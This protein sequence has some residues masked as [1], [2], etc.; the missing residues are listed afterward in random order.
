MDRANL[1]ILHNSLTH[2]FFMLLST[3][4]P[5]VL[6][7]SNTVNSNVS[8]WPQIR[9]EWVGPTYLLDVTVT[10]C[11]NQV[12]SWP[13]STLSDRTNRT[14]TVDHT[15]FRPTQSHQHVIAESCAPY[16]L[17]NNSEM[18][19]SQGA[20]YLRLVFS[21]ISSSPF[22]ITLLINQPRD[23]TCTIPSPSSR[24]LPI[25]PPTPCQILLFLDIH[26]CPSKTPPA[27]H[28]SCPNNMKHLEDMRGET[29]PVTST[30]TRNE[31]P[32]CKMH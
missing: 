16:C 18:L 4:T 14:T 23:V 3:H 31:V 21:A 27:L 20:S 2:L 26:T 32:D 30:C 22:F 29:I 11:D 10:V 12:V 28:L 1:L 5:K 17:V 13:L 6:S 19:A 8:L 24:L 25:L 7:L 9:A 15:A